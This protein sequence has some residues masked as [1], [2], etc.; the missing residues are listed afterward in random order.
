MRI[1]KSSMSVYLSKE[2]REKL[3]ELSAAYSMSQSAFVVMLIND[4]IKRNI[5]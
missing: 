5:L 3:K 1:K 2:M 4:F